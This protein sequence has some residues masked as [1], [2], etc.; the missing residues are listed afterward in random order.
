MGKRE[1]QVDKSLKTTPDTLDERLRALLN[2]EGY[3]SKELVSLGPEAFERI[4]LALE[5]KVSLRMPDKSS[6]LDGRAYE[7]G[8]QA[9]LAAFA[10][11]DLES[12]L[13][14]LKARQWSDIRIAL[15]GIA[16]VADARVVPFLLTAYESKEPLT[17]LFAVGFLGMQRDPR[18]TDALIKALSDRSSDVRYAAIEALGE[19]GDARTIDSLKALVMNPARTTD[20]AD[21]ARQAIR[22]IQQRS[23][24]AQ[25]AARQVRVAKLR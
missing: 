17:R 9:A 24:A 8:L 3:D 21:R 18:A 1:K 22:K 14:K 25:R 15:S 16:R 11:G 2:R 6:E 20:V 13:A 5:R 10:A 7:D 12:V 4:L 23:R 19:C